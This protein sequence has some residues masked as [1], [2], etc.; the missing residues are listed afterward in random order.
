VIGNPAYN[1][2]ANIVTLLLGGPAAATTKIHALDP[3]GALNDVCVGRYQLTARTHKN[4]NVA[5]CSAF[6]RFYK[7]LVESQMPGLNTDETAE[8]CSHLMRTTLIDGNVAVSCHQKNGGL[9]V[10]GEEHPAVSSTMGFCRKGGNATTKGHFVF[11]INVN[12][13]AGDGAASSFAE[14][15]P[16]GPPQSLGAASSRLFAMFKETLVGGKTA[17]A[18][19]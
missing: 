17:T 18:S 4:E 16:G 8:L 19:L 1:T 2:C 11:A 9:S 12:M 5:S 3:S 7:L 15:K 10:M 13:Y 6:G 14:E